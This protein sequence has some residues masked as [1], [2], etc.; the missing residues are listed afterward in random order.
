MTVNGVNL[1]LSGTSIGLD[2]PFPTILAEIRAALNPSLS[3]LGSAWNLSLSNQWCP[4]YSGQP[5]GRLGT[6]G[7]SVWLGLTCQDVYTGVALARNVYAGSAALVLFGY[8]LGGTLPSTLR[9][10]KTTANFD[11]TNTRLGGTVPSG[12]RAPVP[13]LT[14]LRTSPASL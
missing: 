6:A 9:D 13:I 3:V 4:T 8:N 10:M 5:T 2:R 11:F 7:A 1:Y 14:P 12:W